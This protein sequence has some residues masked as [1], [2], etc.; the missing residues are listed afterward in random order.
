MHQS[1]NGL[2]R[3]WMARAVAPAIVGGKELFGVTSVDLAIIAVDRSFAIDQLF[4]DAGGVQLERC[5]P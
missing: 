2:L 5:K 3:A 1:S 4:G